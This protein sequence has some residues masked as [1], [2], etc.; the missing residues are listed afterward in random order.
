MS[1]SPIKA[2]LVLLWFALSLSACGASHVEM[3]ANTNW[4]RQCSGSSDCSDEQVCACGVCTIACERS[5]SCQ[6]PGGPDATCVSVADARCGGG[7]AGLSG[8]ICARTCE[9]ASDCNG[10][11]SCSA[12]T[13]VLVEPEPMMS[14]ADTPDADVADGDADAA[15]EPP[16]ATVPAVWSGPGCD[17]A[18]AERVTC[19]ADADCGQGSLCH[20]DGTCIEPGK[21]DELGRTTLAYVGNATELVLTAANV[22]VLDYGTSD[23]L[24]NHQRDG[25]I[26]RVPIAGGAPSRIVEEID[27]PGGLTVDAKR[28]TWS[29]GFAGNFELWNADRAY[30]DAAERITT[31]TQGFSWSHDATHTYF[32]CSKDGRADLFRVAMGTTKIERITAEQWDQIY[33]VDVDSSYAYLNAGSLAYDV[34]LAGPA[35]TRAN[36][37]RCASTLALNREHW[38][39]PDYGV[40]SIAKSDG[41]VSQ[42]AQLPPNPRGGA[43]NAAATR[44]RPYRDHVYY[45]LIHLGE[46]ENTGEDEYEIRR[47]SLIPGDD[48]SLVPRWLRSSGDAGPE[49]SDRGLFWAQSGHVLRQVIPEYASDP[50]QG[51]TGGPCFG[52][53]TCGSDIACVDTL[54]GVPAFV[55]PTPCDHVQ[56][57]SGFACEEGVCLRVWSGDGCEAADPVRPACAGGGCEQGLVCHVDGTCIEPGRCDQFGRTTLA[58]V[59]DARA[60]ELSAEDVYLLDYGSEDGLGNHREDGA[61]MRAPIDGGAPQTLVSGL[62]Q[63]WSLAIDAQHVFWRQGQTGVA[64]LWSAAR[65][66]GAQALLMASGSEGAWNQDA[67]HVYFIDTDSDGFSELFRVAKDTASVESLSNEDWA[68][69]TPFNVDVDSAYAYVVSSG[70]TA[71]VPLAGG[72]VTPALADGYPTGFPGELEL[73][74]TQLFYSGLMGQGVTTVAKLDGSLAELVAAPTGGYV[75]TL[76]PFREHVYYVLEIEQRIELRRAP[77][78]AGGP[79]ER[80][81]VMPR[82]DIHVTGPRPLAVSDRG[83]F[84]VQGQR[85]MRQVVDDYA[86]TPLQGTP[87]GPCFGDRTC[88]SS[89]SC[90]DT[91]C[92]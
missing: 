38:F 25:A 47:A 91:V 55:P 66:D 90:V 88:S 75:Y 65:A 4:L 85:V 92:Q 61:I 37:R 70:G 83:L 20:V 56:C 79:D 53:M 82:A 9:R 39:C 44:L 5:D 67:T 11:L 50:I 30:G 34:A 68:L 81:T 13:C 24:G 89:L 32:G 1:T 10:D 35:A 60:L 54:C 69:G 84:W 17:P 80:L 49:V 15:T 72:P 73:G 21:C 52:D 78:I 76:R 40:R 48:E 28:V 74:Q 18:P 43:P 58:N 87:A 23:E 77:L 71:R 27:Q 57:D 86:I 36:P 62:D 31:N 6:R 19:A 29:S 63:P 7:G 14:D 51:S 22:Y 64:E 46:D 12:G 41:R 33:E 16:D 59:G 8:S 42:L 45:A 3:D 26:V 2:L